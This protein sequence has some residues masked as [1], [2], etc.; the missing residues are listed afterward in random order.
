MRWQNGEGTRSPRL[1]VFLCGS[2]DHSQAMPAHSS[3][4]VFNTNL[5]GIVVWGSPI[6]AVPIRRA[7]S[8]PSPNMSQSPPPS[9]SEPDVLDYEYG[10]DGEE[11]L[12]NVARQLLHETEGNYRCKSVS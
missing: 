9:D 4:G 2:I 10:S 12:G 8:L 6:V 3:I 1:F 11:R 5:L 7:L